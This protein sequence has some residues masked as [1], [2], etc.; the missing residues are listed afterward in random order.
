[1]I[2]YVEDN[3]FCGGNWKRTGR[4]SVG[5]AVMM[6]VERYWQFWQLNGVLGSND[7]AAESLNR[8]VQAEK[9]ARVA[10]RTS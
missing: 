10:S 5:A 1:M 8:V 4:I 7:S 3:W 2:K 9:P 6:E